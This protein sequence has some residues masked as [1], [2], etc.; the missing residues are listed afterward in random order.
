MPDLDQIMQTHSVPSRWVPLRPVLDR[1]RSW[2]LRA[3]AAAMA[4][5]THVRLQNNAASWR[6]SPPTATQL[7]QFQTDLTV[8][9]TVAEHSP[10]SASTGPA[11]EPSST[12]VLEP[13]ATTS[14]TPKSSA[15]PRCQ[16]IITKGKK[17]GNPCSRLGNPCSSHKY[18]H[19][20]APGDY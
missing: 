3:Q 20:P 15:G 19:R 14:T 2:N 11:V 13:S 12:P 9:A 17:K 8:L 18:V 6:E 1:K 10:P 4:V 5:N 7:R 16:F